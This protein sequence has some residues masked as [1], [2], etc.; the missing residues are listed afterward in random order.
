MMDIYASDDHLIRNN[1]S[2]TR[3]TLLLNPS[4]VAG[5]EYDGGSKTI[6][7]HRQPHLEMALIS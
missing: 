5:V 3:P 1:L 4:E 2:L 6:C 7:Y